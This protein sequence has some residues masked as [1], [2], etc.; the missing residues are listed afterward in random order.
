MP[1]LAV[2][3]AAQ[4]ATITSSVS[5]DPVAT[6][7][8]LPID[9]LRTVDVSTYT[10]TLGLF[11]DISSY[12]TATAVASASIEQSES[13][14]S[15]FPAVISVIINAAGEDDDSNDASATAT[16][17]ATDSP[18]KRDLERRTACAAQAKISNYYSV[19]DSSRSA[20][21]ADP[22]ISSVAL[23]APTP[24][25]YFNNFKNQPG[26]ISA[27]AYLGYSVI[28]AGYDVASCATK[29]TAM[30]GCLSFNI[31][32]ERDPTVSPGTGCTNPAAFAN[33][34]CSFWGTA[35]DN[36]T[37]NNYGQWQSSF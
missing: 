34:K 3:A 5:Y 36:T 7:D 35:P 20:F 2:L 9:E 14:L 13:P 25:G 22:I 1:A 26:A 31:Y 6:P 21:K 33:I 24:S 17:T 18:D 8:A 29:C 30:S 27:Y 28:K 37:A 4:N 15:V 10:S 19:N 16:A 12:R 23:A 11:S 32:F